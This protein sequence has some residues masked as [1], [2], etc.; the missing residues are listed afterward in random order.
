MAALMPN[1]GAVSVGNTRT[2]EFDSVDDDVPALDNPDSFVFC[3]V[4]GGTNSH[5][6][7]HRA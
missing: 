3:R 7:P 1:A 2:A 4:V 5:W 6:P